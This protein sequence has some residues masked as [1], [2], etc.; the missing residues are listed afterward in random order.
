M[1]A[2]SGNE[3][4]LSNDIVLQFIPEST[5]WLWFVEKNFSWIPDVTFCCLR[6]WLPGGIWLLLNYAVSPY[7]PCLVIPLFYV[8][9]YNTVEIILRMRSWLNEKYIVIE[10]MIITMNRILRLHKLWKVF[11]E[12]ILKMTISTLFWWWVVY[13]ILFLALSYLTCTF[14]PFWGKMIE[15]GFSFVSRLIAPLVTPSA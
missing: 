14:N 1:L 11:S 8:A 13:Y 4:L 9:F 2:S 3:F 12:T 10:K 7:F 5:L 6:S 15:T